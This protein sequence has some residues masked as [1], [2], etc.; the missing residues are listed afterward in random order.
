MERSKD[1]I[2]GLGS[3]VHREIIQRGLLYLNSRQEMDVSTLINETRERKLP[4]LE[5]KMNTAKAKITD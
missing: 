1:G 4:L 2:L 3:L 5:P